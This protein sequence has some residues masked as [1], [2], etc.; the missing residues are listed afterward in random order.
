MPRELSAQ[1]AAYIPPA[2]VAG[3]ENGLTD[4]HCVQDEFCFVAEALARQLT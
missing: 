3:D 4:L 1:H 2:V